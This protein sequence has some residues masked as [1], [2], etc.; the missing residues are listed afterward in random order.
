MK[1]SSLATHQAV[2]VG[3][4]A[5]VDFDTTAATLRC[6]GDEDRST[7]GIR[8]PALVRAIRAQSDVV[9]D[10]SLLAFAD[11]SVML[12]LAVLARRLRVR[13]RTIC[14]RGAQPQILTLIHVVGL[15]RLPGVRLE[16][17]SPALAS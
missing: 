6:S 16:G 17:T 10:L 2:C 1:L 11:S 15:H 5:I 3:F 7:Q 14:L 12:D 9:V 4:T 13:G 8:R